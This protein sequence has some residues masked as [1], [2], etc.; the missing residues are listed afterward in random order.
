[1]PQAPLSSSAGIPDSEFLGDNWYNSPM[2]GDYA[3]M[4]GGWSW[5]VWFGFFYYVSTGGSTW[6]YSDDLEWC[7]IVEGAQAAS[8]WW[9]WIASLAD[10]SW[11]TSGNYPNM[12]LANVGSWCWFD[13]DLNDFYN[14]NTGGYLG[15]SGG[16]TTVDWVLINTGGLDATAWNMATQIYVNHYA[17]SYGSNE[18]LTQGNELIIRYHVNSVEAANQLRTSL[19][20]F[21]GDNGGIRIEVR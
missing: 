9:F 4:G 7:Y 18:I 15:Q 3:D 21:E 19:K 16:S 17:N 13:V 1:M 20:A 10:W 14:Y 11:T 12:Y 8:S 6:V 5:S 2:F